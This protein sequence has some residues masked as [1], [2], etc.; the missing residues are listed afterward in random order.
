MAENTVLTVSL[1]D[2]KKAIDDLR[3][4][5]LNLD[6]DSEEYKKTTAEILKMQTK[7][8]QIM[9]DTAKQVK[10]ESG[11]YKAL[12]N[13]L[14]A[15]KKAWKE[16]SDEAERNRIGTRIKSLNDDLKKM[17]ASI[18]VFN[19]NVGDYANQWTTA[20]SQAGGSLGSFGQKA[21]G[22]IGSIKGIGT[23]FTALKGAMGWIGVALGA[24]VTLFSALAKGI[25]GSE[26]HT[27]AFQKLLTPFK[28]AMDLVQDACSALAS[29][30]L[31]LGEYIG[32]AFTKLTDWYNN[33]PTW[34]HKIGDAITLP[35][36]QFKAL[37]TVIGQVTGFTEKYN[38][39]LQ[40][41]N[42][43]LRLQNQLT[44]SARKSK[45]D[46]AKLTKQEADQMAIVSD[47]TLT[48]AQ[49][50]QA[51]DAAYKAKNEQ[52]QI[53]LSLARQ[54]LA[55]LQKQA[56][57]ADNDAEANDKLAEAEAKVIE[58]EAK[59]SQI[60]RDKNNAN[61]ALKK[62]AANADKE[63]T[64]LLD[65]YL[66]KSIENAEKYSEEWEKLS[67]KKL[68]KETSN[69]IQAIN[70]EKDA[71]EKRVS[72]FESM[73]STEEEKLKALKDKL[74][75]GGLENYLR[76]K[77]E[78]DE[79]KQYVDQL[80]KQGKIQLENLNLYSSA[81]KDVNKEYEKQRKEIE[82]Q[83]DIHALYQVFG[84]PKDLEELKKLYDEGSADFLYAVNTRLWD[85]S[86]NIRKYQQDV[87]DGLTKPI[88]GVGTETVKKYIEEVDN[89]ILESG[90][91][92]ASMEIENQEKEI[93]AIDVSNATK[94]EKARQ[95]VQAY[96]KIVEESFAM[97]EV[98]KG[99]TQVIKTID[100]TQFKDIQEVKK[101]FSE[102]SDEYKNSIF[103]EQ[104]DFNAALEDMYGGFSKI[105]EP[106]QDT[107]KRL[108][109]YGV[110][111]DKYKKSL[112]ELEEYDLK[113]K[114]YDQGIE[115]IK[116]KYESAL[117]TPSSTLKETFLEIASQDPTKQ[118]KEQ[119]EL[120][121]Y[122]Y[123]NMF[124]KIGETD[125]E[126]YARRLEAQEKYTKSAEA[127]RKA[128]LKNVLQTTNY[129]IGA[130]NTFATVRQN[131]IKQQLKEGKMTQ[132]EAE[133]AFDNYKK[134]QYA[135]TWV[136]TLGACAQIWADA[137]LGTWYVKLAA[138]AQQLAMGIAQ[139]QQI[140][141]TEIGSEANGASNGQVQPM[142]STAY[143]TPLLDENIDQT[144]FTSISNESNRD[145][146]VYILQSDITE[147]NKQVEIRDKSTTF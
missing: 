138:S 105:G 141:N 50:Q 125:E 71:Y 44:D 117:L 65:K 59:L 56:E 102:L 8:D 88:K 122:E 77:K 91:K 92:I 1:K 2:Y 68:K 45:T 111:L 94:L 46:L 130:L 41:E 123:Q 63:N 54:E 49:R 85:L 10:A 80:R 103:G 86:H 131:S 61:K 70:E 83:K 31:N 121:Q 90:D 66:D 3:A 84:D 22:A 142:L 114:L 19:R 93:Q 79:Q 113:S 116:D 7:L 109:E 4:S 132:K 32:S 29:G 99:E 60:E 143:V 64:A 87:E 48:Y 9:S 72:N 75:K 33:A 115:D 25:Q 81:L 145:N 136:S 73:L 11:S 14:N 51:L 40:I 34:L 17:D 139:T 62:E 76:N 134:I 20:F 12:N 144:R 128:E 18:G 42:D 126:F 97:F 52:A 100:L 124:Q 129:T 147:S 120:A 133:E 108:G 55:L 47:R 5:L 106:I 98:G 82:E 30:F 67:M 16:T 146:R 74:D 119:L 6:K 135:T 137:S 15:L 28:A 101:W 69:N 24:I 37:V 26:E 118:L 107:I 89:L 78:Y 95:Y 35:I 21:T 110:A 36:R 39:K 127:L 96:E 58:A 38:E 13:E 140:K 112:K 104:T 43:A 27:R 57:A 23:A 53:N